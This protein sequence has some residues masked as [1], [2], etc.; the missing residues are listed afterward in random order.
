[1]H[2]V[3][4]NIFHGACDELQ[5]SWQEDVEELKDMAKWNAFCDAKSIIVGRDWRSQV[6]NYQR[7][8]SYRVVNSLCLPFDVRY[9]RSPNMYLDGSR[10]LP[11]KGGF[12]AVLEMTSGNA[13]DSSETN[14][15]EAFMISSM[16]TSQYQVLTDCGEF[17][18][19][20][21]TSGLNTA[22]RL[23][24][25]MDGMTSNFSRG[26]VAWTQVM[27]GKSSCCMLDSALQ[28]E[29]KDVLE[30]VLGEQLG[31]RVRVKSILNRNGAAIEWA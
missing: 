14:Y 31:R 3:L 6:S 29:N 25:A 23:L 7:V 9:R 26:H 30:S 16:V 8:P 22:V 19:L 4:L 13:D 5:T 10:K 15:I 28:N 21:S 2:L 20:R 12:N 17:A 18:I 24:V 27:Y 1:M 11:S